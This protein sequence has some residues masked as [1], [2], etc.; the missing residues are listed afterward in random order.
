MLS[1]A[2][3]AAAIGAAASI[4]GG[5]IGANQARK[6]ASKN[7]DWQAQ[8]YAQRYQVTMNDMRLAGLNPMLAYSQGVGS[9]PTGGTADTS[10]LSSGIN[11]AGNILAQAQIRKG[12][13]TQLKSQSRLTEA[14]ADEAEMKA[15]DYRAVG[16]SKNLSTIKRLGGNV[17][18]AYIESRTKTGSFETKDPRLRNMLER[19]K[20]TQRRQRAKP[21]PP[22]QTQGRPRS[23]QSWGEFFGGNKG[24]NR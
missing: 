1:T 12:Q 15:D 6:E 5:L 8:Q 3:I 9:S 18:K 21:R 14:T 13:A 2:W 16:P 24:K 11:S 17:E 10:A 4:G 19:H 22:Y 7:R 23:G 20:E